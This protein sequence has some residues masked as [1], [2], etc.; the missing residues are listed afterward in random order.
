[1][2]GG[3]VLFALTAFQ[4]LVGYRKIHF[5]GRRHLKVHKVLAWV[6]VVGAIG[7]GFLAMLYLGV[8]G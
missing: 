6:L 7:H 8:L 1:M 5:K 4:M 3:I 2:W